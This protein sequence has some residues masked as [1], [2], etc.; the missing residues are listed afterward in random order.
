MRVLG[1]GVVVV[2]VRSVRNGG[3]RVDTEPRLRGCGEVDLG[4]PLDDGQTAR[5]RAD[6]F[7]LCTT[8]TLSHN[9]YTRRH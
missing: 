5:R 4:V 6:M 1:N 8:T 9:L 7:Y 2:E 3:G